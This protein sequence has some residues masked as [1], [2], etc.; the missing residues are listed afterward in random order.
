VGIKFAIQKKCQF[1]R[2]ENML[3]MVTAADTT[4]LPGLNALL[5]NCV[6][7]GA[8]IGFLSPVQDESAQ[9]YWQD[10]LQNLG[11]GLV[12]WVWQEDGIIVGTVQ[13]SLC[14]KENG[15]HRAEVQKLMIHSDYRGRGMAGKLMRLAEDYARAQSRRLLLLDTEAGSHAEHVYRHLGWQRQGEIPDFAL[16]PDGRPH[17]TAIYYKQL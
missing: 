16:T 2:V 8:S 12:L 15:R 6:D 4:L 17:A 1:L 10:V 13:L 14:Q 3:K 9:A 5:R 7:N 11:K